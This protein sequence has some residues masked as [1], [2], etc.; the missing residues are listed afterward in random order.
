MALGYKHNAEAFLSL[1]NALN[2]C[3]HTSESTMLAIALG[4]CGFFEPYFQKKWGTSPFYLALQEQYRNT[5]N[6]LEAKIHLRLDHIRPANH[7]V[8]RLALLSKL[9]TDPGMLFFDTR[10]VE[11]WCTHWN[12]P[13]RYKW[14]QMKEQLLQ[15]LSPYRDLYWEHHYTFENHER[16]QSIS[17]M[18]GDLRQE[19][20]VNVILP[21]LYTH[22]KMQASTEESQAFEEFYACFPSS[23]TKK[24]AYLG[25]RF[26]GES[27]KKLALLHADTQ[28]G[29]YQIH[30]DFCIHY[31]ASCQG[32]PFVE[33]YFA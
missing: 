31:E 22:V 29:A 10:I 25:Q 13:H 4:S 5:E 15:T 27:S 2:Q 26:F 33:R 6:R 9:I 12:S 7:P 11:C 8:R 1:F 20:L 17:L 30:R 19:I 24:G 3:K 14:K 21:F 16:P 28:Q 18:G 32:C 23:K